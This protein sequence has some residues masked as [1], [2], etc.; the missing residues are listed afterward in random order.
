MTIEFENDFEEKELPEN[1]EEDIEDE[2]EAGEP[3][4][5]DEESENGEDDD[6]SK[7]PEVE[8]SKWV[9][10]DG[11]EWEVPAS[12]LPALMKD[13]DYR[14]NTQGVAEQRKALE[15]ERKDWQE[16]QKRDEEDFKLEGELFN[17]TKTLES[18]KDVD[19]TRLEND[20]PDNAA[21]HFRQWQM[22]KDKANELT[23]AKQ[24]RQA[25]KSQEAQQNLA[26]RLEETQTFAA[27][28]IP[29]WSAELANEIEAYAV[30]A[31]FDE[32]SIMNNLT[33]QFLKVLY[34]GYTASKIAK[35]AAKPTATKSNVTPL[36]KVKASSGSATTMD[37]DKMSMPDYIKWRKSR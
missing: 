14:Q 18:Y 25:E 27:K 35:K 9:D 3:V 19:W 16:R 22:L 4:A 30:S 37:P 10:D 33:P 1:I 6:E 28:N 7:E 32:N 31:G 24:Q 11:N 12:I 20:D 15:M 29:N 34:D 23:Q 36:R 13:K 26:K 5:D 2:T 21:R 17:V 8:L